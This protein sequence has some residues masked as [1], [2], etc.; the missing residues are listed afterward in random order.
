MGSSKHDCVRPRQLFNCFVRIVASL[1]TFYVFWIFFFYIACVS[2]TR[3]GEVYQRMKLIFIRK[4][5]AI[6]LRRR[7]NML[8]TIE[9]YSSMRIIWFVLSMR[10]SFRPSLYLC[11]DDT[12]KRFCIFNIEAGCSHTVV[13]YS[14]WQRGFSVQYWQF[15][16]S[17]PGIQE[18]LYVQL[19]LNGQ[20]AILF[21]GA[22]PCSTL[23]SDLFSID[24]AVYLFKFYAFST[25]LKLLC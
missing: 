15:G 10:S 5:Y 17:I 3:R 21:L 1:L 2:C 13:H 12:T 7:T 20:S 18:Y 16:F 14:K 25:I 8:Y 4:Q 6:M 22:L 23:S 24:V 19:N 9:D 11:D